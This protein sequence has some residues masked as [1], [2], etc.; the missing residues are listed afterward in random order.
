MAKPQRYVVYGYPVLIEPVEGD[1]WR[2]EVRNG[3]GDIV[4]DVT[5]SE[6]PIREQLEAFFGRMFPRALPA[7][8]E[9][10]EWAERFAEKHPE[11]VEKIIAAVQRKRS[12]ESRPYQSNPAPESVS[13]LASRLRF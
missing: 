3:E 10:K 4:M 7:S 6:K 2:V 5:V 9:A 13:N 12:G 8:L 1:R 11:Q